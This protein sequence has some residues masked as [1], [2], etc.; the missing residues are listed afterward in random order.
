MTQLKIEDT[1]RKAVDFAASCHDA[2]LAADETVRRQ[3][4][5]A[6]FERIHVDEEGVVEWTYNQPFA[7]LMAAHGASEPMRQGVSRCT[8]AEATE[9]VQNARARAKNRGRTRKDPSWLARVFSSQCSKD[10]HLAEGM[11]FEPMVTRSATTAFEA[12]PFVR[13]GNLPQARLAPSRAAHH[14]FDQPSMRSRIAII[15]G[16]RTVSSTS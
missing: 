13:S 16:S 4:N 1:I 7:L 5:Q 9:T 3:M 2:Y 6:F 14:G 12:A 15:V 11:G 8:I 10:E